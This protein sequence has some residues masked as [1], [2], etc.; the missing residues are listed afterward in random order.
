MDGKWILVMDPWKAYVFLYLPSIALADVDWLLYD[1]AGSGK[2]VLS[3]VL[4]R[5]RLFIACSYLK[6]ARVSFN[7]LR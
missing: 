3:Y 5:H 1:V 4:T 2:S 7:K 6:L